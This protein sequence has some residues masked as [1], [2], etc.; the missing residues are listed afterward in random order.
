MFVNI[1][2]NHAIM[3]A[4]ALVKSG[5]G[6]AS[7]FGVPLI[8]SGSLLVQAGTL[9]IAG[10]GSSEGTVTVEAGAELRVSFTDFAFEAAAV[11]TGGGDIVVT[12]SAGLS[13]SSDQ[14][15]GVAGV[16]QV[17]DSADLEVL[18]DLTIAALVL[19]ST[20]TT[21]GLSGGGNVTV[22]GTLDWV[23]GGMIGAGKT[24]VAV[25]AT[26]DLGD[27]ATAIQ[28]NLSLARQLEIA[29]AARLESAVL[30]FGSVSAP[31]DP[32]LRILAG[33]SFEV[34]NGAD[35][36][37]AGQP[38]TLAEIDNQGTFT[39]SGAGETT[40]A[41]Q[42]AFTHSGTIRVEEDI[43]RIEGLFVDNDGEEIVAPGAELITSP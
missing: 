15:L 30:I 4:G 29:G 33:G 11:V 17:L 12:E 23:S 27:P 43:L 41:D 31:F 35:M 39:K 8:D 28:E 25:G 20:S 18:V 34:V 1:G 32:T 5:S 6:T 22:T 36:I 37:F 14:A 2:G 24:S 19:D 26:A 13:V 21:R 10:G 9:E 16:I 38:A 42:I 3:N 7:I 40:I